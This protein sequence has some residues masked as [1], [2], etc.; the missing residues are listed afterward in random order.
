[1]PNVSESFNCIESNHNAAAACNGKS[2]PVVADLEVRA[3]W[4]WG[5][6]RKRLPPYA[7]ANKVEDCHKEHHLHDAIILPREVEQPT[8]AGLKGRDHIP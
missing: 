2:I 3:K 7:E 1:L 8:G 5:Q 6:Q 4:I